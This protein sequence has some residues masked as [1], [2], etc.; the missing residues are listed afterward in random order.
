MDG[1]EKDERSEGATGTEDTTQRTSHGSIACAALQP[2]GIPHCESPASGDVHL[3]AQALYCL[4][5]CP[6]HDSRLASGA[7]LAEGTKTAQCLV[8]TGLEAS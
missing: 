7:Q 5:L 2:Q 8:C 4:V 6:G 1:E 3:M